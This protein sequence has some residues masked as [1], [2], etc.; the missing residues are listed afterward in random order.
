M[1]GGLVAYRSA[2]PAALPRSIRLARSIGRIYI[3]SLSQLE[4]DVRNGMRL[5]RRAGKDTAKVDGP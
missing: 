5:K 4:K 3:F 1:Y 2:A